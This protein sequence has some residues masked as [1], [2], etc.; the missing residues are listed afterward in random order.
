M[1]LTSSSQQTET[2]TASF[3]DSLHFKRGP[4]GKLGRF[5]LDA[6]ARLAEHGIT[7]RR[8]SFADLLD[9]HLANTDSW[10]ALVECFDVRLR[11]VDPDTS[12]CFIGYD[13]AGIPVTCIAV[14]AEDLG[15]RTVR[16]AF[17]D[18][19][20]LYGENADAWR[21]RVTV[22]LPAEAAGRLRGHVVYPGAF[23]VHPSRRGGGFG[24][25]LP[26]IARF[27]A[28]SLWPCDYEIGIAS[29][30]LRRPDVQRYSHF[31]HIEDSYI[32]AEGPRVI[33]QGM[34]L[35][36]EPAYLYER[37]DRHVRLGLAPDGRAA[38]T[39]SMD[40][41]GDQNLRRANG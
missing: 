25:I 19:S 18:L 11:T 41:V 17:E 3:V 37:L 26:E 7:L 6:E 34:F 39:K 38:S 15:Q 10:R 13:M 12:A 2:T 31:Q 14:K 33:Y 24:Y 27:Y 30:A 32:I 8:A 28:L 23:W 4:R 16:S 22:R 40:K 21:D 35:W 20:F 1:T 5:F 36:S 29:F 9:V